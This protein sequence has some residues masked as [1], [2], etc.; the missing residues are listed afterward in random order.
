[1]KWPWS[2]IFRYWKYFLFF[3]LFYFHEQTFC[4]SNKSA[5]SIPT[6]SFTRCEVNG[7]YSKGAVASACFLFCSSGM[8]FPN[9]LLL[10]MWGGMSFNGISRRLMAPW[11]A[12]MPSQT[13]PRVPSLQSERL[14]L[15][16]SAQICSSSSG[17][18]S[19]LLLRSQERGAESSVLCRVSGYPY[20]FLWLRS[21]PVKWQ[22]YYLSAG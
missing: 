10:L 9:H 5:F 1:M 15:F 21:F 22:F 7:N 18:N 6:S 20:T 17:I 8:Y 3:L 16:L 19:G 14:W 11:Q 13:N 12:L 4:Q 2:N